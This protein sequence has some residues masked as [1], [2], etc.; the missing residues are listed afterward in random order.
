MKMTY[1][2]LGLGLAQTSVSVFFV[3][4][5]Y[6][7]GGS[8]IDAVRKDRWS[9]ADYAVKR[10]T[11]L[12]PVLLPALFL[13]LAIDKLG[14]F[15]SADWH[16]LAG[17]LGLGCF[18]GNV[19]FL[20]NIVVGAFG[21]N[22]PLWS[23]T[24]EFWYYVLA[25]VVLWVIPKGRNVAVKASGVVFLVAAC[26]LLP[27]WLL[28]SSLQW[29]MGV[30][31]YWGAGY[32]SVD[33]VLKKPVVFIL[34]YIAFITGLLLTHLGRTIPGY[35]DMGMILTGLGFSAMLPLIKTIDV[36]IPGYARFSGWTAEMS[37]T[38]YLTHFPVVSFVM[39]ALLHDRKFQPG[40]ASGM[41]CLVVFLAVMMIAR[42]FW[43]LFE[44]RTPE[45]RAWVFRKISQAG[46][47]LTRQP[48][49][50]QAEE[51]DESFVDSRHRDR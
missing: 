9:L 23:L 22:G 32:K 7:V 15:I 12:Y 17:N 31:V 25:P 40:L 49:R 35:G 50:A 6:F 43:Y 13:T 33:S 37:Y 14:W 36:K 29:W 3:L 10:L 41:L 48:L 34:A 45:I 2:W 26:W 24:F 28:T 30:L 46:M 44:R 16:Y 51:Q 5:G 27:R 42:V 19:V 39:F 11:R 8:I 47:S 38:L 4:S 18:L 21:T 20:E 1:Y